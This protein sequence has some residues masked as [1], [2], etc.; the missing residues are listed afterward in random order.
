MKRRKARNVAKGMAAGLVGGLIATVVMTQFQSLAGKYLEGSEDSQGDRSPQEKSSQKASSSERNG[1][2]KHQEEDEDATAK[3]A[4]IIAERVLHRELSKPEK[5]KAGS[6]IHYAFG[7]FVGALYGAVAELQP[8]VTSGSGLAWGAGVWATA[9]E[10]AV[11]MLGLSEDPAQQ[12]LSIH[13]YALSSHL[14]Y[15]GTLEIVRS[16]LRKRL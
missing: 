11:P 9:D 2:N 14:V 5:K 10:A 6:V 3:L 12:P 16:M 1:S 4:G 15:G 13:A 7:S 8:E